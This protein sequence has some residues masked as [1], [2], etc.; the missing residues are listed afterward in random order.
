MVQST[1]QSLAK[2]VNN[3]I[4]VIEASAGTGK[5]FNLSFLFVQLYLHNRIPLEK[6]CAITFTN[7]AIAELRERI[8]FLFQD[9]RNNLSAQ[10]SHNKE[11]VSSNALAPVVREWLGT[12][13]DSSQYPQVIK[14]CHFASLHLSRAKI[15][16]IH[17]FFQEL[18]KRYY[19]Y[20]DLNA[21]FEIIAEHA[22]WQ[23]LTA[24]WA[25]EFW[26][27]QANDESSVE[28]RFFI[29]FF[30]T[31]ERLSSSIPTDSTGRAVLASLLPPDWEF[32][33]DVVDG[34]KRVSKAHRDEC[35]SISKH[36][37]K[38]QFLDF[39]NKKTDKL[40][41]SGKFSY[42]LILERTLMVSQ[43]TQF[44]A[45]V[46][47][48]IEAILIDEFQDTDYIQ[49]N[50]IRNIFV[51][52]NAKNITNI[53][54]LIGDPKQSIYRFRSADIDCYFEAIKLAQDKSNLSLNWRSDKKL[55]DVLNTIYQCSTLAPTPFEHKDLD[56]TL[57]KPPPH[58][59]DGSSLLFA[60][61]GESE[62]GREPMEECGVVLRR[63]ESV[64][65]ISKD[66]AEQQM[67]QWLLQDCL[68][69]CS[70]IQQKKAYIQNKNNSKELLHY[71]DIL[72]LCRTNSNIVQIAPV[73]ET[74]RYSFVS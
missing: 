6:L 74:A 17:S 67:L 51:P 62:G 16:T 50:V 3:G 57:V 66:K 22:K 56:Y 71:K 35:A 48:D 49:W 20:A 59:G 36:Y 23:E 34:S 42:N 61:D 70:L 73:I 21:Q 53:V 7:L 64:E 4:N 9:I 63:T 68:Q 69:L 46:R 19:L 60:H 31:P 2:S 25:K 41:H 43:N 24:M 30:P 37:F 13:F 28:A 11:E 29:H 14:D 32:Y 18:L 65:R 12:H 10:I 72:I 26:L 44:C 33:L 1:I 47:E 55:L 45:N 54:C 15:T 58:K 39:I 38:N 27:K 8:K 52:E 5:T 40:V